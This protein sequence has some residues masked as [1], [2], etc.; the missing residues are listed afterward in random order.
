MKNKIWSTAEIL[1]WSTNYLAEHGSESPRL[2]AELLLSHAC[3][4]SR[5]QL[6]TDFSR[7]VSPDERAQLRDFLKR[8]AGGEPVAYLTGVREF[9]RHSFSVTSSVLIPRPE[10]ELLV[11]LAL[12]ELG[13]REAAL[14]P[15]KVL[16]LGTGS[17]C[18]AISIALNAHNCE[19]EAWEV[20]RDSAE[21]C[22]RN[23]ERLNCSDRV[24]L[25][26]CD[27]LERETWLD[28]EFDLIISNPP[29]ITKTEMLDLP[30][31]V[32][33]FEPLLALEGGADG[34]DFYR[35]IASS[36]R[37]GL[38]ERGLL[39]LELSPQIAAPCVA[40][41]SECGWFVSLHQDLSGQDRVISARFGK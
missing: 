31:T 7:P 5:I 10:S 29:Y 32:R 24:H 30:D 37:S 12:D 19:V 15:A 9:Y 8:R 21:I 1:K 16:D 17:G 36:A 2:D 39:L 23:I 11:E 3:G 18:L 20:S 26:V 4:T 40:L 13:R 28:R 14:Q 6:Y 41:F 22:A 34:L 33:C 25:R 27:G 38:N 35:M